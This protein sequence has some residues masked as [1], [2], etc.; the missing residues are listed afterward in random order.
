VP[1]VGVE[2][3]HSEPSQIAWYKGHKISSVDD[4]DAPAGRAALLYALSGSRGSFGVKGTANSL[5]PAVTGSPSG[6]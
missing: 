2:L 6:L 4:L 5:L 1:A 3:T